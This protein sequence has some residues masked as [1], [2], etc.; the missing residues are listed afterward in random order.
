MAFCGAACPLDRVLVPLHQPVIWKCIY[1]IPRT[2]RVAW[3]GQSMHTMLTHVRV[4]TLKRAQTIDIGF[5]PR[6]P[7]PLNPPK[8]PKPSSKHLHYQKQAGPCPENAGPSPPNPNSSNQSA[9]NISDCDSNRHLRSQLLHG[10]GFEV[11]DGIDH[12]FELSDGAKN[13]AFHL[14]RFHCTDVEGWFTRC[15]AVIQ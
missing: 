14:H 4:L 8:K 13:T 10:D 2:E 7:N 6:N 3:I 1:M 9:R 12:V 11:L 15:T 5:P